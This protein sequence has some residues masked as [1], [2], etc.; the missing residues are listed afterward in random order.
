ME[1][2][3]S[4]NFNFVGNISVGT[5]LPLAALKPHYD[6]MLFAYGASEDKRL[7]LPGEDLKGIYSARAFV[8]WYNGLP[9]YSDLN[10]DLQAGDHAVVIGQGNVALDVARTLLSD[11][12][13]LRGTDMTSHAIETLSKSTIK[14]VTVVGRRGPV[15]A[16]FTIKELREM[17]T[18]PNVALRND[19]IDPSLYPSNL[20]SLPRPQRRQI[21]LLQRP[22]QT[23]SSQTER[24][25]Q[26]A[27]CLSPTS[28]IASSSSASNP[29]QLSSISFNT[30]TLADPH[31]PTSSVATNLDSTV[32]LDASIAFR[33]IGYKSTP[34]PDFPDHGIPF[35]TRLG[36][37]P[38]DPA[39]RVLSPSLGPGSAALTAGHLPGMYCAGW[40]KRGPTG[41][42]ATT[43]SDAF[44]TAEAIVDDWRSKAKF[45]NGPGAGVAAAG[46]AGAEKGA[47]GETPA[48]WEG[49]KEEA[50]RR[51]LRRV[52]WRE[53]EALDE[54]ERKVGRERGKMRDK[55]TNIKEMLGILDR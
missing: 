1:V 7:G 48:G 38:N 25:F 17:V 26:L 45:L 34:L 47:G 12:D 30:T 6:A 55:I 42:I 23:L 24:E 44:V 15:Q 32:T 28:F 19:L 53:W 14:R 29:S 54:W 20:K 2:A 43:M 36:I 49:V 50:D 37:I 13:R 35:D 16:A 3:R 40:V 33:S 39:G 31:S 8:G 4:P 10:P 46:A 9:E 18:L 27:F 22:P 11:I 41:V 52:S 51:G 21:E 5:D